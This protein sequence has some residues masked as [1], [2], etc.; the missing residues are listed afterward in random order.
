MV[1][2]HL[3]LEGDVEEVFRVLRHLG[4]GDNAGGEVRDGPRPAPAEERTSAVDAVP[5]PGTTETSATLL[6]GRWTE[7]LAADFMAGLEPA[8][9]R[10][11][12]HVL[13][14][15][16]RGIHRNTLC[17]RT[18][19]SLVELGTLVMRMGRALGRFQRERGLALSRRW[20]P[21]A[22]CRAISSTPNSP[23]WRPIC[24]ARGCRTSGPVA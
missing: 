8:G 5:E 17:Q 23:R 20:R 19:L 21:T 7:E 15:A 11:A 9:R 24:S 4:G 14:A 2:L 13:R 10:V 22:R 12:L 3:E 18:D 6:P 1:K 16:E